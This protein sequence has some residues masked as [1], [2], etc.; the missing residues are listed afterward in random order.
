M[1]LEK[2]V[3]ELILSFR[4]ILDKTWPEIEEFRR[5]D[6]TGA[7][8]ADWG[9]SCWE[10]TVEKV[11]FQNEEGALQPYG[12]GGNV[13]D[14]PRISKPEEKETHQV[15]CIGKR[16]DVGDVLGKEKLEVNEKNPLIFEQFVTMRENFY[17]AEHPFDYCLLKNGDKERVIKVV[18]LEFYLDQKTP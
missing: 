1:R 9:Q 4:K 15:L 18:E 14:G 16:K 8:L 2:N 13:Y 10:R 6:E 12:E 5:K 11:L 3:S 17:Y 7:L